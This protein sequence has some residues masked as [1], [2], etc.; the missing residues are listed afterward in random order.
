MVENIL[1][2]AKFKQDAELKKKGGSKRSNLVGITK[3][4]DANHAGSSK[5]SQSVNHQRT[6]QLTVL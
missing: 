3:L 2:W 1:S 5:V 4:D 6:S